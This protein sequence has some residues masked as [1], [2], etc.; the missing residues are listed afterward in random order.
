MAKSGFPTE[1]AATCLAH[2]PKSKVVQAYQ[3]SDLRERRAE[4]IQVG[5]TYLL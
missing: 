5:S 4:V 2:V 3:R 1:V